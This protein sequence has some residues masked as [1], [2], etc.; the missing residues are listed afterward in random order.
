MCVAKTSLFQAVSTES[1]VDLLQT[2][3]RNQEL[4]CCCL[5]RRLT[6]KNFQECSKNTCLGHCTCCKTAFSLA[7]AKHHHSHYGFVEM[8]LKRR[9]NMV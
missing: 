2:S 3:T 5:Q 9:Y 7:R 1:N 6:A 8:C 4:K